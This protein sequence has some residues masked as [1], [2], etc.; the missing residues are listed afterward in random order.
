[1]ASV[2][3]EV[4]REDLETIT[5]AVTSDIHKI[6]NSQVVLTGASGFIGTWLTL[7]FLHARRELG[8]TGQIFL[9]CR[10]SAPL[11][12]ILVE[13]EF[14]EGY[15]IVE[16]DVR[17]FPEGVIQDGTLLIHA[18]TPARAS[19]NSGNPLEMFDIIVEG[20]KR[21]LYLAAQK[22]S[23]RFLF[24]SSGAVY[25]SQPL[26][27]SGIPE[28]WIGAP[29]VMNPSNAYH[30]GKRAAELLGNVYTASST[31]EFV[32]ARLFAFLAPFLP[33]EEHFAAGNFLV[34]A[35]DNS[36]IKINSGGG[37]VRSYMYS[38]DMCADLWTLLIKGKNNE[39]YNVGSQNEICLRDLA[40][41]IRD[42]VNPKSQVMIQGVDTE[43]N[44][45]RYVP[46]TKKIQL[47]HSRQTSHT[48]D[49]AIRR[50]SKWAMSSLL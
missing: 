29:D 48:L 20:Q 25:G 13:A 17:D 35:L 24:L 11:Q 6:V 42:I 41:K 9:N 36:D 21:L 30:E 10:N 14:D 38:T 43:E 19:L 16:A 37:S 8:G 27:L 5:A 23:V 33:L 15:E 40:G 7:S 4:I 49:D 34:N 32:S 12:K 1:M 2:I 39:A 3:N 26:G 28:T 31:L 50:T 22:S 18:A 47:L 44:V 46:D 45:S